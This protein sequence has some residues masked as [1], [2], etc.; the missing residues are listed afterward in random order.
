[1]TSAKSKAI[2]SAATIFRDSSN[3]HPHSGWVAAIEL[4]TTSALAMTSS[5]VPEQLGGSITT[6][7]SSGN[8]CV[9]VVMIET[10]VVHGRDA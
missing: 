9:K 7:T 8:I 10:K 6:Y 2:T 5:A 4:I 1:M 3:R